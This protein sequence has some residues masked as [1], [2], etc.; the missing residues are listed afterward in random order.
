MTRRA[1]RL[2]AVAV[3][4]ALAAVLAAPAAVSAGGNV[5]PRGLLETY[6]SFI[7]SR[8]Y[9][10]AYNQWSN[11]PQTYESFVAGY[12]DTVRVDAYFGG[13]QP[14]GAGALVGAVPGVLIGYRADGSVAAFDGCYELAY[15][16]AAS[17]IGQ[18]AITGADF[19]P[20]PV[21]PSPEM[22]APFLNVNCYPHVTPEGTYTTVQQLLVAYY[23]AINR[24]D[25]TTAYSLWMNPPQTYESF[26]AGF[27]DTTDAVLFYGNYQWSGQN[28]TLE[29]GRIPAVV[30]GYRTDGSLGVYRG[31]FRVSYS[32]LV[33]Q[34]WS[35]LGANLTP[36]A[37]TG[38]P[39]AASLQLALGASCY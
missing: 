8:N 15:T 37:Y 18:W 32:P 19:A 16:G 2:V 12:A 34:R 14:G 11:P 35:I 29:A 7:N 30:F 5:S 36:V 27:A 21:V 24:R 4:A 10:V 9:A 38:I 39:D 1:Y 22:I 26:A 33:P 28:N 6:Y 20:L 25:F 17:G 23:N 13:F 3:I 31:C